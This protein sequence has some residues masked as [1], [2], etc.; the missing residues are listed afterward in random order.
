[1]IAFFVGLSVIVV[2][3]IGLWI[4]SHTYYHR[5]LMA[6][7]AEYYLKL[8]EKKLEEDEVIKGL[9]HLPHLNDVK[10]KAPKWLS[11]KV[12][13]IEEEIGSMQIFTLKGDNSKAVIYLHGAGYVR[14]P[15]K[16][17]WK[18]AYNIRKKTGNTII[19][20]KYPKAPNHN[21]EEV[22][23]LL[24]NLYLSLLGKYEKIA[25]MGDSSG[26]G[27]ALGLAEDFIIKKIMQPDELILL[28][29]WVDIT[30][31]NSQIKEYEKVDP[32][33]FPSND[34]I[35]GASWAKDTDLKN[36][37]VSPLYGNMMG[38]KNVSVFIGTREVL[39]PDIKILMGILADSK[40]N[41][42]L[43]VGEG[44]NHVYPI[45]PIP[46]AKKAL[47]IITKIIN[48]KV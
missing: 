40:V 11:K 17:H 4:I 42:K 8:T 27:L 45:Y 24:T 20:V 48:G 25:L 13:V 41:A 1:M 9:S 16:Q 39:Y 37:K 33:V 26:G 28:S 36:Y 35:W 15:R 44:L 19:F 29:P 23:E 47:N 3:F 32:I 46:E 34:R 31:S 22:Y 43:Y 12:N 38:L 2:I 30:L 6:T 18:F 5:S 21:F 7:L 10:I 14:N